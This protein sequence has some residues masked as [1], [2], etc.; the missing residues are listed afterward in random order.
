MNIP[1]Y[2]AKPFQNDERFRID[3]ESMLGTISV[4]K[5]IS[6]VKYSTGQIPNQTIR[7]KVERFI[8]RFESIMLQESIPTGAGYL[9]PLSLNIWDDDA[10]ILWAQVDRMAGFIFEEDRAFWYM[11]KNDGEEISSSSGP[12]NEENCARKIREII[13]QMRG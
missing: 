2:E 6:G 4:F 5:M 3:I 9:R 7:S 12:L 1:P 8:H 10:E 13:S 11:T